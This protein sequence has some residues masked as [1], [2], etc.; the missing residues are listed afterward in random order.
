ME[1]NW[2]VVRLGEAFDVN[3]A[4]PIPK[5]VV[6]PFVP[7]EALPE[8]ARAIARFDSRQFTGGGASSATAIRWL[9]GSPRAW[10]TARPPL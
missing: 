3:P 9:H 4:R 7:M 10:R 8:N 2:P 5:G 1:P 6:T